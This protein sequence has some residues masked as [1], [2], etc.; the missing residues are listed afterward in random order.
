MDKLREEIIE[1]LSRLQTKGERNNAIWDALKEQ[2]ADQI[3][4][5]IR[6]AGWQSPT[7]YFDTDKYYRE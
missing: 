1:I 3:L 4:T 6:Q 7:N 2:I 5:L